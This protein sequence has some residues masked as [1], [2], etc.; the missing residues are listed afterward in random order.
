[1]IKALK[2]ILW[3]IVV[4]LWRHVF[5]MYNF[6]NI[7]FVRS[8]FTTLKKKYSFSWVVFFCWQMNYN[9]LHKEMSYIL[10]Q[11]SY[12]KQ[13]SRGLIQD[14]EARILIAAADKAADHP[15]V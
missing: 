8:V 10:Y 3:L 4:E 12:L 9:Y 2:V 15:G 7:R 14:Q 1:M 13:Y 6:S 11:M 5:Q